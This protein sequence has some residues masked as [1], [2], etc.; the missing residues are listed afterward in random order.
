MAWACVGP[1][2]A[3]LVTAAVVE[4]LVMRGRQSLTMSL[5]AFCHVVFMCVVGFAVVLAVTEGTKP[6]A[7]R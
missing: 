3:L 6:L 1:F 7:S 4:F 2:L 5:Q